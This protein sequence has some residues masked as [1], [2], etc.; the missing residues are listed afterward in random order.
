[1]NNTA[2]KVKILIVEDETVLAQDISHRLSLMNYHVT[3]IAPSVNYALKL[4]EKHQDIDLVLIDIVLKGHR[5]GIELANI[6]NNKHNIPFIFLTSHS[7]STIIGRAKSVRPYAFILKPFNDR[8]VGVAIEMALVNFFNKTPEKEL[9]NPYKFKAS[10]NQ[11]L[12]IK[13]SLFLKKDHH[14]KR[15][16]L[17]DILFIQA[18]SNYSTVYTKSDRYLYSIVL[19]KIEKQLPQDTFLRT[20]RSYVVNIKMVSGFE[21]NILFMGANKI[22]VSKTYKEQVFKLFRTI[23]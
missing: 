23:H 19:K 20:H 17:E 1:M 22:P 10:E 16:P 8:Q 2:S 18:D 11:V 7:D 15:V 14:F 12:Q 4:I 13:N 9:L 6:I 21:G 3:G 5:D